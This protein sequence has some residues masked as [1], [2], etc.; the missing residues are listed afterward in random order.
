ML[1]FLIFVVAALSLSVTEASRFGKQ[2]LRKAIASVALPIG[3]LTSIPGLPSSNANAAASVSQSTRVYF[4]VGCFWHVQHEFVSTE[5]SL[6]NRDRSQVSAMTGY[7]G[8]TRVGESD[9]FGAVRKV[10]ASA[11]TGKPVVCYHNMANRADYGQLG[12]GEVVQVSVPA[13]SYG[14]FA[15]EYFSLFGPDLERPDK[16]DRGP[17]YR[18]LVGLP[19]GAQSPLYPALEKAAAERGLRLA[20]GKGDDADTLGKRAVW[21]MDSERFPFYQ[22]EVYHQF[23]DDFQSKAY[24]KKYNGLADLAFDDGRLKVTGC[25]DRV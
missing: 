1:T 14:A 11:A 3:I 19:G 21:V 16:G 25:P 10:P 17:E 20:E 12:H 9:S 5:Q 23:H 22:A 13:A 18:S 7:A 4:G 8:G 15:K 2:L 24:G 6:L